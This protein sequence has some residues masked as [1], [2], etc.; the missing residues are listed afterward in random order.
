MLLCMA[1]NK[2]TACSV[3]RV[4]KFKGWYLLGAWFLEVEINLFIFSE[5]SLVSKEWITKISACGE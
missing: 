3:L 1:R 2:L 5:L 4:N